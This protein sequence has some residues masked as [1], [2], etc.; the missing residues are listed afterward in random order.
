MQEKLSTI[1]ENNF[2]IIREEIAQFILDDLLSP[3]GMF[4]VKS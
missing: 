3:K 1:L 4:R 2:D